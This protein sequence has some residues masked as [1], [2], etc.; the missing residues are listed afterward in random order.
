MSYKTAS[1]VLCKRPRPII[2]EQQQW[3]IHIAK[4]RE[5]MIKF[6]ADR[7]EHCVLCVYPSSF[8]NKK[9]AVSHLR[10]GHS[11]KSLID[12]FYRNILLKGKHPQEF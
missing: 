6:I 2:A 5:D 11:K 1:C 7:F 9:T 8:T 3:L 12:W 10:W 4:H